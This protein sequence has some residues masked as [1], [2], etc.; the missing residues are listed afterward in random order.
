LPKRNYPG[1]RTLNEW[2]ALPVENRRD[3]TRRAQC[4]PIDFYLKGA[5]R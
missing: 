4:M 3:L 1:R 5:A 2:R